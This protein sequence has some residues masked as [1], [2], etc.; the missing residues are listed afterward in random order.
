MKRRW[1]KV[2]YILGREY[3]P[4]HQ[5]ALSKKNLHYFRNICTM[6]NA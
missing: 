5:M 6:D 1:T 4:R 3:G 2:L